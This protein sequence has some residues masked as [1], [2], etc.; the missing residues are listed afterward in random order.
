MSNPPVLP[1]RIEVLDFGRVALDAE[2]L[3]D[4][5]VVG[6]RTNEGTD[7]GGWQWLTGLFRLQHVDRGG[8]PARRLVRFPRVSSPPRCLG[9]R[10][11]PEDTRSSSRGPEPHSD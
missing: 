3:A 7:L 9:P 5:K 10:P 4:A 6:G 2:D 1:N 8:H 11:R